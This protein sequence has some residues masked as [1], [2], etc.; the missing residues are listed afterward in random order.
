MEI[1]FPGV[2]H[3]SLQVNVLVA[4]GSEYAELLTHGLTKRGETGSIKL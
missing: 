3:H 1:N 2:R 4:K